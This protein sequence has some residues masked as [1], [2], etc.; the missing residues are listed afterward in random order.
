MHHSPTAPSLCPEWCVLS[1]CPN[2]H[3]PPVIS[4]MSIPCFRVQSFQLPLPITESTTPPGLRRPAMRTHGASP[5]HRTRCLWQLSQSTKVCLQKKGEAM[6]RLHIKANC[7]PA[8]LIPYQC[9]PPHH[10]LVL[11]GHCSH[12]LLSLEILVTL[13]TPQGT[14]MSS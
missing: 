14:F 3:E 13:I 11:L 9:P 6:H 12:D 7:P 2:M 10:R 1:T 5:I 8:P 4:C